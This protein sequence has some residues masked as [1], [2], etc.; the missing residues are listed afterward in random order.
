MLNSLIVLYTYLGHNFGV[1]IIIFT[2]IIR[3]ITLPLTL[4]QLRASKAMQSLA[5]KL[6]EIQRKY[7][8]PQQRS[9]EQMKLYKEHGVNPLGCLG[10]MVIQF[11]IWIGLYQSI[12]QAL[13]IVPER[14]LSL[15]QHLYPWSLV[16]EAVPLESRFLWLNLGQP[17]PFPILP[18]L[19]GGSMWVQQKMMTTPT[20]DPRSQSMNRMMQWMMPLMFAFL[21]LSFPSGLALYWV[22]SNIV[23]IGMQY[24]VTGWGG[25]V[26]TP[27]T[28]PVESRAVVPVDPAP[29]PEKKVRHGRS[30]SKRKNRRR[31]YRPG[32][33]STGA[34]N[35]TGKDRGPEQG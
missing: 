1:T 24:F 4:R 29:K 30:R 21:T 26:T 32:P 34:G 33:G 6:Q 7:K 12:I 8:D 16:H 15:S 14:L 2:V 11:P 27:A 18:L 28:K 20:A 9:Q 35:L 25:L 22:A 3:L 19:V 31:G 10:P 23:G 17:D 5:P 13:A